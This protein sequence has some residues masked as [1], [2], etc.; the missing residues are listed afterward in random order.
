MRR[1]FLL[2][3]LLVPVV[4]GAYHFGPGQRQLQL[5]DVSLVVAEAEA[6]V[7]AERWDK[8]V[9][10]YEEAMSRLPEGM[11]EESQRLRLERNKARMLAKQL[12]EAHT[13]LKNMLTELVADESVDKTLLAETRAALANSQYY[14]TWLM[15]MEGAGRDEWLPEIEA[16][17]QAFRLLAENAEENGDS[18][19]A[20]KCREDLESSIRLARL[21]LKDL[22]G[23]PLPSQ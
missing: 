3:W 1:F 19:T 16:A 9:A 7:K 20:K 13:D 4:A 15:R 6:A 23:L 18:Q 5:D 10:K 21:D 22:Q 2:V 14:M 12:P 11:T 8:A 17:R